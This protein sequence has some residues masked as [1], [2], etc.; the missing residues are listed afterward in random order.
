MANTYKLLGSFNYTSGS[1][2]NIDFVSIPNTY[3]D[4]LVTICARSTVAQL[5]ASL[6]LRFN[7]G[8][9]TNTSRNL[10]GNGTTSV[11]A[12]YSDAYTGIDVDGANAATSIHSNTQ[13]YFPNYTSNDFKSYSA[14]SII[15]NS[16]TA[17]YAQIGGGIWSSTSA[18]NR[19]T[20]T[21]ENASGSFAQFSTAYLYGISRT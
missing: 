16:A 18:I 10:F 7:G 11:S 21:I 6:Y 14:E 9:T 4:L 2:A 12:N 1:Q 13:L 19:L 20:F 3:N 8:S 5:G 15:E 17:S